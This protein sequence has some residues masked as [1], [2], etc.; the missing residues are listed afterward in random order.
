MTTGAAAVAVAL[1]G[2]AVAV[3]VALAAGSSAFLGAAGAAAFFSTGR[4]VLMASAMSAL[5]LL[6]LVRNAV[7]CRKRRRRRAAAGAGARARARRARRRSIV[8]T[9]ARPE[10]NERRDIFLGGG[11]GAVSEEVSCAFGAGGKSWEARKE[12]GKTKRREDE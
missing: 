11:C 6:A 7:L 1:A 4:P 9:A 2:A 8:V 3:A 12:E 10:E 5:A